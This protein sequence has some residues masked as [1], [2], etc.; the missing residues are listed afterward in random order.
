MEGINPIGWGD[1][2]EDHVGLVGVDLGADES[3]AFAGTPDM[4]V[5]WHDVAS[6]VEEHDAGGGFG[7]YS[8]QLL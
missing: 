5:D 1:F 3:Q 6:K 4:G 8:G 2:G 7:A